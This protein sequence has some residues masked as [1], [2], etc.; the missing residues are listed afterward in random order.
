MTDVTTTLRPD[1][2]MLASMVPLESKI[3]DIGCGDGALIAHLIAH[4]QVDARGIELQQQH[5]GRAVSLGL[6]VIQGDADHDL[7]HYPDQSFDIVISSKTLQATKAPKQVLQ[8]LLR[9]GKKVLLSVPNFGYWYN[10]FYLSF[11]GKMPVSSSLSYQWYETPNIHFCTMEDFKQ[12][13]YDIN[14]KII[15]YRSVSPHPTLA[16]LFPNL[17]TETGIFLIEKQ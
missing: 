9:I 10:R 14:A 7:R 12:L 11:K 5:V 15:T 8:E 3:L 2:T 16:K 13:C 1:L 17:W 6:P 4:R